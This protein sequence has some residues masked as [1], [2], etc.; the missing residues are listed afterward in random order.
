M[1]LNLLRNRVTL[2]HC[3]S[4]GFPAARQFRISAW[5][6]RQTQRQAAYQTSSSL[7]SGDEALASART[8]FKRTGE[9]LLQIK[10]IL[11][12]QYPEWA[13][14]GQMPPQTWTNDVREYR[15]DSMTGDIMNILYRMPRNSR[16]SRHIYPVT[17]AGRE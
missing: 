7:A 13:A 16:F 10:T 15:P 11:Q 12:R 6:T 5:R 9:G 4:D 8:V 14:V 17:K 2:G 1:E 3:R